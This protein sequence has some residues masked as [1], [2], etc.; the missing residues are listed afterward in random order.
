MS[1]YK[2]LYPWQKRIVDK[3]KD[4]KD[5]GLFLDM[6]LGKTPLSLALCEVNLCTKVIVITLNAKVWET[7][8]TPGSW[9]FWALKSD[10]NWK[11]FVK[12]TDA[13]AYLPDESEMLVTNYEALYSRKKDI[14]EKIALNDYVM[15]FIESCK[16]KNVAVI[17]DESHKIKHSG[18]MQSL[19][20]ASMK[21][22]LERS[23]ASVHFYLLSGTPFT[24]GYID[25]YSQ[26]KMLGCQWTKGR[27]EDM[28]CIRGQVPGLLSWQQPIVG[29]RNIAEMYALVHQYALTIKSE[30]IVDLPPQIFVKHELPMSS[31]FKLYTKDKIKGIDINAELAFRGSATIPEYEVTKKMNN[32]FYRNI[33]YPNLKWFADTPGNFWLRARQLSAGFQGNAD[34]AIWFDR[35]RLEVI[36]QFLDDNPDNYVIFC[37]FTPEILELYQICNELGYNVD[38]Y[39]GEAKSL[40]FYERY[41]KNLAEGISDGSKNIILSNFASGS[42]G[43]NW[44][45]YSHCIIFSL[46]MYK[47]YAQAIKRVHRLGQ[48]DSVFYHIFYQK[49]WLDLGMLQSLDQKIDYNEQIFSADLQRIQSL[50]D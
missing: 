36:K 18:S 35:S 47:D 50:S 30:E 33:A 29:Y 14:H 7:K 39:C 37:N 1:I 16:G 32:P 6:G 21:K 49:N 43:M 4:R 42:T 5:F 46:P 26:L 17:I 3:F 28:F 40:L 15:S 41:S 10:M 2:E 31:E 24:T 38:M 23:C 22:M 44:Q 45:N 34:Q 25:L 12:K 20:I 48:K 19:A 9:Y 11:Q 8:N 13:G 27:F